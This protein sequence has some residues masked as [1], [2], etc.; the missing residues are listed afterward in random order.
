VRDVTAADDLTVHD[1]GGSIFFPD[2]EF[3]GLALVE[4]E[5]AVLRYGVVAVV[6]FQ[7]LDGATT[8]GVAEDDGIGLD[9][10]SGAGKSDAVV[11]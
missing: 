9:L 4:I 2:G 10:R 8:G 5:Q 1:A 7:N 6:L 3:D 11:A